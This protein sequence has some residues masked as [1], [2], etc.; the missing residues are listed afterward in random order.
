MSYIQ[1]RDVL[2]HLTQYY[3]RLGTLYDEIGETTDDER[4]ALLLEHMG[5][6]E[7]SFGRA[8]AEHERQGAEGVLNTWLQYEFDKGVEEAFREAELHENPSPE[9]VIRF[10]QKIDQSLTDLYGQLAQYTD[11]RRIQELFESLLALEQRKEENYSWSELE[12]GPASE[13]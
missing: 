1:V 9:E 5:R 11:A 13:P 12:F 7:R 10:S 2:D 8:V 3:R 4:L 6:H